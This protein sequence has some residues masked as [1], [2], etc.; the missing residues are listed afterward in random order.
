MVT[1]NCKEFEGSV[2]DYV[3]KELDRSETSRFGAHA[4]QCRSCRS[5]LEDVKTR[6]LGS[7]S[8]G[9][10]GDLELSLEKIPGEHGRLDC[11]RFED[12]IT[13]FLDG[14]VPAATYHRFAEHSTGCE[15]CSDLLTNV[16]Y[17]VAA[18]HSVHTYEEIDPPGELGDRLLA[19]VPGGGP[20]QSEG[21][22]TRSG[23]VGRFV[24][25]LFAVAGNVELP[26]LPRLAAGSAIMVAT[27]ALLVSGFSTG[28]SPVGIYRS[29]HLRVAS[30]YS[31]GVG[32]Y[33]QKDDVEAR[34]ERVSSD[35]SDVWQ[36]L[37]G[38][39][40]PDRAGAGARNRRSA[41]AKDAKADSVRK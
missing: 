14:F 34:L 3:A 27:L 2:G 28:L 32:I 31:E 33:S 25:R 8:A 9:A 30:V 29:A 15:D 6:L 26:A 7:E 24:R 1:M 12:L 11:S 18:C 16:V 39:V 40:T 38:Q 17:A 20:A 22:S 23:P 10:V 5:L 41:V 21:R 37:G 4:L 19:I 35:I 36:T 13:E